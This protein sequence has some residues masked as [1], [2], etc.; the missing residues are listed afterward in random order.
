ML[1]V[2]INY[3]HKGS[4]VYN[5]GVSNFI[6][7]NKIA[8]VLKLTQAPSLQSKSTNIPAMFSLSLKLRLQID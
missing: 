2:C 6:V 1:C 3:T 4:G 8:E 7:W 5:I